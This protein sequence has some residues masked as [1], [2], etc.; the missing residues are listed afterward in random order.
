MDWAELWD[1]LHEL[2]ERTRP[3]ETHH[4]H[5]RIVTLEEK[6]ELIL[7]TLARLTRVEFQQLLADHPD[8]MHAVATLLAS[9]ELARRREVAIRQS[10]PFS[11]LWIYRPD[12]PPDPNE[13]ESNEDD[14][15]D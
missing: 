11:P 14:A 2:I 12:A 8:K 3:P 10:R 9:L 15:A 5:G 4:V 13:P 6:V 7:D 1:A